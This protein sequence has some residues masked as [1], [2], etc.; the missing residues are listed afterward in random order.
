MTGGRDGGGGLDV[1]VRAMMSPG[2]LPVA[3]VAS[4]REAA[5]AMLHHGVHAVLVV[6]RDH[7]TPL[8]WVTE[9]GLLAYA[10]R[11]DDLL[12]VAA[13]IAEDVRLS[14]EV[15]LDWVLQARGR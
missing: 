13:A 2:V 12:P 8:G 1:A 4:A 7:G 3:E 14:P 10:D 6:G 11:R 5:R 9:R 15:L